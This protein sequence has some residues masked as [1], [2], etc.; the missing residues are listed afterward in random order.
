MTVR[1]VVDLCG[2]MV[3]WGL[4][5]SEVVVWIRMV[6]NIN[7]QRQ[8]SARLSKLSYTPDKLSLVLRSH[9]VEYP[10]SRLPSVYLFIAFTSICCFA[11]FVILAN[12]GY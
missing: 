2:V 9:Q 8:A 5:I 3:L 6:T 4:A 1:I 7:R 10:E 12:A 11:V